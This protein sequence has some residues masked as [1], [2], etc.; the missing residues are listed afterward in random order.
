MHKKATN[1]GVIGEL[2]RYPII[3][4]VVCNTVNYY[5][6][7]ISDYVSNLLKCALKENC[8]LHEGKKKNGYLVCVSCLSI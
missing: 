1:A 4:D 6:R 8:H 5:V 7:F 2:G 3:I